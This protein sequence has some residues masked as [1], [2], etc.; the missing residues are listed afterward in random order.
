[1][2]APDTGAD[3]GH[4]AGAG[5]A[6][7]PPGQTRL[8]QLADEQ[9]ALRRV[10]TLGAGVPGWP[11]CSA[12]SPMSWATLSAPRRRSSPVL[13]TRPGSAGSLRA[14][15]TV[16]GAYGRVSDQVPVGF[17]LP[18]R[19]GWDLGRGQ[20]RCRGG[21]GQVAYRDALGTPR[22]PCPGGGVADRP[23]R[24]GRRGRVE[25]HIGPGRR[26]PTRVR[27]P[28]GGGP[29][30][31][32]VRV[33]PAAL[34]V[35]SP[36]QVRRAVATTLRRRGVGG[37]AAQL[38]GEFGDHPDTAVARMSWALATIHA[39]YPAPSMAPT[40]ILRPLAFAS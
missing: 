10:A 6:H 32:A 8:R 24:Q 27:N 1:M 39:V 13:I 19:A 35:A 15:I 4:A 14:F 20:P 28:V 29:G 17:Q 33:D 31:V 37:C 7:D 21:P 38:A 23:L 22:L 18:L 34:R 30:R 9:A 2:N 3:A 11:R 26:R 36:G 40:P 25:E 12:R 16:V 5:A